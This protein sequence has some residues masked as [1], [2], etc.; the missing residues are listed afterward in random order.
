M[1][2]DSIVVGL[3]ATGSATLAH[4]ARAGQRVLGIDRFAPPH[5]RGSS[6][7]ETRIYRQ[8]YY[9]APE[10]VPLALRA[11]ELWHELEQ[12]TRRTLFI[13]TGAL[14]I[15]PEHGELVSGALAS[16]RQHD[17]PH[18]VLDARDVPSRFPA[19]RP[20]PDTV[21]L[22][23]PTAGVL[24][25]ERCIASHLEVAKKHGAEILSDVEVTDVG[26]GPNSVTVT[27]ATGL[28]RAERIVVAAGAWLPKLLGM[29]SAF[30]VTR[31]VVHWFHPR[32]SIAQAPACPVSM[33]AHDDGPILYTLPDVGGG[34]KAGLHHAG[35][36]ADPNL[37]DAHVTAAERE[38]VGTL[39]E[40]FIPGGAGP[41]VRSAPCYYTTSPDHHFVIGPL[42][43]SPRIIVASACSG[44]G[45]KFASALGESIALLAR[46]KPAPLLPALFSPERL[47]TAKS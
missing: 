30:R 15:G 32:T 13:R 9:E 26:V 6:H 3:G 7:G 4:L 39:V 27:V 12:E 42:A 21:T 45:F 28:Y 34:L 37:H 17:I 43:R 10:Y 40:R 31:E 33:I 35:A 20:P 16:A 14:T 36:A 2:F 19:F 41:V 5:D 11:L 29:D 47:G 38:R 24:F 25:P 8:A 23:E 46:N 1:R 18:Q 44:H 22:F